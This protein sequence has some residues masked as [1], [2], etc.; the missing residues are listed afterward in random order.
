MAFVDELTIYAEAGNGG[1]GIV[2]WRQEKYVEKGGPAGGDGGN[3]G[4]VYFKAVRDLTRLGDYKGNP[5]LK[6]VRGDDGRRNSKEGGNKPAL[7]I[8]VPMGSIVTNTETQE[9]FQL[10]AEGQTHKVLR[11]GRGGYGNE[12]RYRGT[13]RY[14]LY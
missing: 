4:D 13:K 6:A 3:G 14:I 11:G 5:K 10:L 7:Y 12:R 9:T 8:E 2:S 1:N